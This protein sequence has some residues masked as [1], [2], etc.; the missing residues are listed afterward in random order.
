MF[1]R[2]IFEKKYLRRFKNEA[3]YILRI[4]L[5]VPFAYVYKAYFSKSFAS[6]GFKKEAI[7]VDLILFKSLN[8]N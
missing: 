8:H 5:R 7:I 4:T 6:G 1:T 3:S 2:P